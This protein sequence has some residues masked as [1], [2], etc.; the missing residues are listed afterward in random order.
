MLTRLTIVPFLFL[1]AAS[2]AL[3]AVAGKDPKTLA[4][5]PADFPANAERSSERSTPSA[6]LPTGGKGAAYTTT[7][8]FPRGQKR[9]IVAMLLISVKGESQARALYGAVARQ[10]RQENQQ[11]GH[12]ALQLPA[13]GNEQQAT[14]LG[15][16]GVEETSAHIWVRTRSVVWRLDVST[17][18]VAKDY[19][20]S[21]AQSIAE[22]TKYAR[23]LKSRIGSG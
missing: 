23:K 6:Q 4:L 10:D 13:F 22:L 16:V 15:N 11:V 14:L 20:F 18:A 19:G 17:D 21:K 7:F 1:V 12:R 3:A 2:S 8:I 9:E 5:R